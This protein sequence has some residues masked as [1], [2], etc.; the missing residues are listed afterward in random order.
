M[1]LGTNV[2]SLMFESFNIFIVSL[3]KPIANPP[4]GGIPY[5]NVS[6]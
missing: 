2:A 3:S 1:S 5:L 6:R 4:C